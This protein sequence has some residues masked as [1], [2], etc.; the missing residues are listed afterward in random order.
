MS[1]YWNIIFSDMF[2]FLYDQEI[3]DTIS[4]II[5]F[6]CVCVCVCV[7]PN[8]HAYT[9]T[10]AL[11]E[12]IKSQ[13]ILAIIKIISIIRIFFLFLLSAWKYY[14]L[15]SYWYQFSKELKITLH[16]LYCTT[17]IYL[18]IYLF[19]HFFALKMLPDL[20]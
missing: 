2:V 14:V 9:R 11:I 17:I 16:Q 6:V 10:R 3:W 19:S 5:I 20:R 12:I 15:F 8:T 4:K 18:F 1:I 13:H 7:C